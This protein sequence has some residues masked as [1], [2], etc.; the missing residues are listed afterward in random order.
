M[1]Y[2]VGA[3]VQLTVPFSKTS[4]SSKA[5]FEVRSPKLLNVRSSDCCKL[6]C[7]C[8]MTYK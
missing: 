4:F 3:Q 8:F 2:L 5:T 6:H 1:V 7:V